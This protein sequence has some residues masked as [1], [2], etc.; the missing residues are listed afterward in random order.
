MF[1]QDL[2]SFFGSVESRRKLIARLSCEP[3]ECLP[4][5]SPD[6]DEELNSRAEKC[7]GDLK[8]LSLVV[9]WRK[10]WER[11]MKVDLLCKR[12]SWRK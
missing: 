3:E 12:I 2:S 4:N 6:R 5:L 9:Q 8:S 1:A 11:W 7:T 10:E